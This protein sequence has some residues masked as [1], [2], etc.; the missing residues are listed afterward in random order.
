MNPTLARKY[1]TTSI[2]QYNPELKKD[3]AD[4][5]CHSL[6]TAENN[7]VLVEIQ[8][9]ASSTSKKIQAIQR[10]KLHQN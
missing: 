4:L 9:K 8:M 7:Y 5:L 6:R 1:T 3:T 10:N 2:Y